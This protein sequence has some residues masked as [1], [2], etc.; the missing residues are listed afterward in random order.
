MIGIL[1][2]QLGNLRSVANS[3]YALGFDYQFIESASMLEDMTHLIIPGVGHF[4]AAMDYLHQSQ[5][6]TAIQHFHASRRPILGICLGMQLLATVGYEGGETPGL[7]WIPGMVQRFVAQPKL[8]IPHVGWNTVHFQCAHPLFEEIKNQRD[9]YFVHSY[10]FVC[11]EVHAIGATT[12]YGT[13]FPSIV[14]HQHVA[15]V[16]F[17]P[18]KS[19]KNG[20]KLLENFCRWDGQC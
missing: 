19:Q 7:G 10:H 13:L 15:G 8:K 5:L 2:L 12:E 20:L 3:V 16:Q 14:L 6:I 17:H 18:E 1:D 11:A 4:Q 9:F